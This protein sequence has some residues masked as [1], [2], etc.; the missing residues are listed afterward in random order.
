MTTLKEM[1]SAIFPAAKE[2]GIPLVPPHTQ[3]GRRIGENPESYI[4]GRLIRAKTHVALLTGPAWQ[5]PQ[6]GGAHAKDYSP[7]QVK[8]IL[9][10]LLLEMESRPNDNLRLMGVTDEVV[11]LAADRVLYIRTGE[12]DGTR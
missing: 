10:Q 6:T 8:L 11:G 1:S 3:L 2:L 5:E 4:Y 12:I 7:G 9:G